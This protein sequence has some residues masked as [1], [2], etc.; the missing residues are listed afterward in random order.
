MHPTYSILTTYRDW[1]IDAMNLPDW[2]WRL[3]NEGLLDKSVSARGLIEPLTVDY[4]KLNRLDFDYLGSGSLEIFSAR[5]VEF[6]KSRIHA[7]FFPIQGTH[8]G[9]PYTERTFFLAHFLDQLATI[10]M[11]QSVY[12]EHGA[13]AGGGIRNIEKLVLHPEKIHNSAAF[14][15]DELGLSCFRNDLCQ[16][17]ADAGFRGLKFIP[18]DEYQN[19]R[20][21]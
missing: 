12:T 19:V 21:W 20:P 13:E 8:K 7:E 14:V 11:E 10:D 18:V 6:L 16:E 15:M 5:L 3:R 4:P 1:Q 17:I 9:K 2:K